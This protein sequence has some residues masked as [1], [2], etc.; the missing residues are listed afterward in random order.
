MKIFCLYSATVKLDPPSFTYVSGSYNLK[1][2]RIDTKI[3]SGEDIETECQAL[4]PNYHE[5]TMD[6]NEFKVS[7]VPSNTGPTILICNPFQTFHLC[8]FSVVDFQE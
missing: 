4:N 5:I 7:T 1:V 6:S 8:L 3:T 2:V